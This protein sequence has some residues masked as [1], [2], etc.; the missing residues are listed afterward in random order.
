MPR[1]GAGRE[2]RMRMTVPGPNQ[3]PKVRVF[4]VD[5]HHL[6][7]SG[8]AGRARRCRRGGRR[9]RR[10]GR[11]DRADRRTGPR[12]GARSTSTCP[13]AVA[14]PSSRPSDAPIP[15]CASSLS[16]CQ[17]PPKMSSESSGPA[18]GLCH[19]DHLRPRADRR[20]RACGRRRRRVLPRLAGFVLDAFAADP[21]AAGGAVPSFDPELDQLTPRE[22]RGAPAASP[23]AMPTRRWPAELSISVKTVESHVSAVLRKLQLSSRHQLTRWASERRL[24]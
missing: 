21:G 23:A 7:L 3:A 13:T 2:L 16:R 8:R 14:K 11:G 9:C 24:L 12:R 18:R 6:F 10:G 20:C 22:A 17:M 4:L 19:E 5:D 1:T 15:R